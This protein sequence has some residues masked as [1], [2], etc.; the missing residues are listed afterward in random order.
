MNYPNSVLTNGQ[1]N[2][3][4]FN[5]RKHDQQIKE[6][7]ELLEFNKK[8]AEIQKN[9]AKELANAVATK[10]ALAKLNRLVETHGISG[11]LYVAS[12]AERRNGNN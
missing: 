9:K 7:G 1:I 11:I 2:M 10:E 4:W 12:G 3:G 8:E 5:K 6:D